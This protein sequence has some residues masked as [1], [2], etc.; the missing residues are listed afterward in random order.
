MP[1]HFGLARGINIIT[2]AGE[3]DDM[4]ALARALMLRCESLRDVEVTAHLVFMHEVP[5]PNIVGP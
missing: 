1:E 5:R 3:Q 4:N 2:K